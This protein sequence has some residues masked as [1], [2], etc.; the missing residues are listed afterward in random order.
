ME[1]RHSGSAVDRRARRV[2]LFASVLIS[3]AAAAGCATTRTSSQVA[4]SFVA[5][6]PGC[7]LERESRL[8]LGGATMALVRGLAGLAA[9]EVDEQAHDILRGLRRIEVVTYRVAPACE[10]SATLALPS[11]LTEQGWRAVVFTAEAPG[12]SSWVLT[13]EG[14]GGAT[15]GMLVVDL[16]RHELEVVRLDGDIDRVLVVATADDP[17]TVWQLF[18][19]DA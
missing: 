13:R 12:Q 6:S 16:D 5:S 17:S 2:A 7:A 8:V 18:D 11:R 1:N 15:S 14:R 9:G 4:D 3:V 10:F 19:G